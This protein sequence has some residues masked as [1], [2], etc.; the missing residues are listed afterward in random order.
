MSNFETTIS[1]RTENPALSVDQKSESTELD[2]AKA[3]EWIAAY[4]EPEAQKTARW[5]VDHI[6][7]I[8]LQDF[9]TELSRLVQ[10]LKQQVPDGPHIVLAPRDS[11][12]KKSE[13]WVAQMAM[14]YG[15]K[16]PEE[17]VM[18]KNIAAYLKS[19]PEIRNV[20]YFDDASYSGD[21]IRVNMMGQSINMIRHP[22][23]FYFII[24]PYMTQFAVNSTKENLHSTCSHQVRIVNNRRL[25][26][27]NELVSKESQSD[28][29]MLL[30]AM[31]EH[32]D[33]NPDRDSPG[34]TLTFFEHKVPDWL[35]FPAIVRK[36]WVVDQEKNVT[37]SHQFIPDITPPYKR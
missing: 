37:A 22:D 8:S 28:Q 20:L 15:L 12:F 27:I 36:G 26:T 13:L 32:F 14:E 10:T 34:S 2:G 5:L 23:L 35:S 7:R 31:D 25:E 17:I 18:A 6:T 21:R 3:E 9:Q 33:I 16:P 29:K 1:S 24:M 11:L 30:R 19:H 4:K